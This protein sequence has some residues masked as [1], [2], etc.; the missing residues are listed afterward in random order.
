V[1]IGL[2]GAALQAAAG[3]VF[4]LGP[5][6]GFNWQIFSGQVGAQVLGP[7]HISINSD[8]SLTATLVA[9]AEAQLTLHTLFG[10]INFGPKA[11]A[12]LTATLRPAVNNGEFM[13]SI[14][15]V[16]IPIFIF[17]WGA[18]KY[19]PILFLW[20]G[21]LSLELNAILSPLLTGV[22]ISLSI[23]KFPLHPAPFKFHGS[24]INITLNNVT[25]SGQNSLLLVSA[26]ATVS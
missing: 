13:V 8:G 5:S 16:P 22:L 15:S 6:T 18:F 23:L 2:D 24:E 25:T 10:N 14:E 20:E 1:Y 12:T 3:T 19:I 4:P 21:A 7:N 9:N 17:D 11:T 26:Q